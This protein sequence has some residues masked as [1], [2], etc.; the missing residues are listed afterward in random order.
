MRSLEK[1]FGQEETYGSR[2]TLYSRLGKRVLDVVF[3]LAGLAITSPLLLLCAV[4]IRIDSRGPIFFRQ[5]RVGQQ[6]RFFQIIKLRTMVDQADR[7]G[8]K[9][10]A[11]G[12]SRI[13][14]V[15]KWLRR[16]KMDEIPQLLNVLRGEMSL[17]GPRPEV[18]EYVA[19]YNNNQ[20]RIFELKPGI[21][22][23]A[24]VAF[25]DEETLLAGQP[26]KHSFYLQTLMPRKLELDLAYCEKV[27]FIA[28]I[29]LILGT[30]GRL[31]NLV[32]VE[33][34]L[35]ITEG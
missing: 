14:P 30:L 28:D 9:L 26:D 19:A 21:T 35:G 17:V 10:T 5:R 15:G 7:N 32:K 12:D 22:G 33:R 4:A 20:R 23:P 11:S 31:F 13:T 18:P 24:S 2:S 27:S 3:A 16:T 6:G 1:D 25:V 8:L 29:K 34:F